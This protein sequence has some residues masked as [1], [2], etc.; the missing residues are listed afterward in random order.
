MFYSHVADTGE[1]KE[2]YEKIKAKYADE[3]QPVVSAVDE[4][5]PI[6]EEGSSGG[7]KKKPSSKGIQK[8]QPK[9]PRGA[10]PKE[11][12]PNPAAQV[13][14]APRGDIVLNQNV[15]DDL[16]LEDLKELVR[17]LR[18]QVA[19]EQFRTHLRTK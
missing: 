10:R 6:V 1:L 13:K 8:K 12:Q 15:S 19:E 2:T 5:Q 9:A 11:G 14:V 17:K 4:I 18:R 7:A 16:S 3:L